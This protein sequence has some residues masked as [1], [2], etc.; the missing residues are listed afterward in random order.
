MSFD[1]SRAGSEAAAIPPVPR[2]T[3][4]GFCETPEIADLMNEALADRRM[5]R[6]HVKV[7]MGGASAAVEAYRTAP[8]PNLIV[9]ETTGDREVLVGHL[10]K[11]AEYCDAGT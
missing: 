8:T 2:I 3:V 5:S 4:Q 11:L 10:D 6:A 9:I 7:G 1:Q